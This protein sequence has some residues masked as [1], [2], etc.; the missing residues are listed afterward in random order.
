M[1]KT[2]LPIIVTFLEVQ[3]QQ[4]LPRMSCSTKGLA[5]LSR[6]LHLSRRHSSS[7]SFLRLCKCSSFSEVIRSQEFC[8]EQS[9]EVSRSLYVPKYL[10]TVVVL[11]QM[12]VLSSDGLFPLHRTW[13]S[14]MCAI[15]A[16]LRIFSPYSCLAYF[17]P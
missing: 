1:F 15:P 6:A 10:E 9:L 13:M 11:V 8:E 2:Y 16:V 5:V 3:E 4:E 12:L 7:W 17:G 14:D